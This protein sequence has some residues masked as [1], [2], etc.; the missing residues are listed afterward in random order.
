MTPLTFHW[1]ILTRSRVKNQSEKNKTK[2][3]ADRQVQQTEPDKGTNNTQ[4]SPSF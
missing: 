2:R 1:V 4:M 3:M